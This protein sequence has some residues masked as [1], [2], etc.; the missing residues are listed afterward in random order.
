VYGLIL[1]GVMLVLPQGVLPALQS[2]RR[3]RK[4]A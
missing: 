3:P 1:I 2:L 4:R